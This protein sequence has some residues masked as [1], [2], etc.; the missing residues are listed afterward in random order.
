MASLAA[1]NVV[2]LVGALPGLVCLDP[3]AASGPVI[4]SS[5]AD[6]FWC[7]S[8]QSFCT[9]TNVTRYIPNGTPVRL[10]CW[11]DDRAPF[12][13]SSPRWFYAFLRNGQEGYLWAPQVANQ[14]PTPSCGAVNWLNVSNWAIGHVGT[15]QANSTDVRA[16]PYGNSAWAIPADPSG[17]SHWWSGNCAIFAYIGWREAGGD[18]MHTGPTAQAIARSYPLSQGRP[19]RGALI[20]FSLNNPSGPGHVGLSLGNWQFV[21]TTGFGDHPAQSPVAISN[22]NSGLGYLGWVYPGPLT[23]TPNPY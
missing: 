1:I 16:L 18:V 17:A 4:G 9:Q 2:A 12:P 8:Q 5:S 14:V 15:T 11:V 19:P 10:L 22:V 23:A 21:G 20:F 13:N 3:A 6:M 7:T